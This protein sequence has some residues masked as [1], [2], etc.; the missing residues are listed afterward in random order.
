MSKK[1][2]EVSHIFEEIRR[3]LTASCENSEPFL[4]KA[5]ENFFEKNIDEWTAH[6][7]EFEAMSQRVERS[8]KNRR[9]LGRENEDAI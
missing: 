2:T 8:L 1:S 3:R 4:R 9:T 6:E 7:K 5:A